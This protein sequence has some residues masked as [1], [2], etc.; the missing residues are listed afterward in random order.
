MYCMFVCSQSCNSVGIDL[1]HD[2]LIVYVLYV[3]REDPT[4]GVVLHYQAVP[5]GTKVFLRARAQKV[6]A[7]AT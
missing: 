3:L 1:Y 6:T 4:Q 5:A 2:W 7:W